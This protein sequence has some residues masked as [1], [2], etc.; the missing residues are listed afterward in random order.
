MRRIPEPSKPVAISPLVSFGHPVIIGSGIRTQI[1]KDR[2]EAGESVAD[3]AE[4][5]GRSAE[6]IENAIRWETY[7]TKPAA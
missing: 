7:Q 2:F 3:L 6:E 5:Y 1:V 4:D